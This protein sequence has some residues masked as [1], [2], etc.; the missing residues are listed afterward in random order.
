MNEIDNYL[1]FAFEVDQIALCV[2]NDLFIWSVGIKQL[3]KF[4]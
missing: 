4:I 3:M 1:F 2:N